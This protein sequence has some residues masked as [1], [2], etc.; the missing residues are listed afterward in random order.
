[1]W[2]ITLDFSQI[3]LDIVSKSLKLCFDQFQKWE[4]NLTMVKTVFYIDQNLPINN[5]EH[6]QL[7]SVDTQ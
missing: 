3:T 6:F 7:Q 5:P 4:D 1:M 2:K